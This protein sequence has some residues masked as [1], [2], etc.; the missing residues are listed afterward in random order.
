MILVSIVL[1]V[2]NGEK[3]IEQAIKSVENQTFKDWELIIVDDGSN[4]KTEIIVEKYLNI[5]NRIK[6]YKKINSGLTKSLNFGLKKVKGKYIARLDADDIWMENKLEQ[7]VKVLEQNEEIYIC[8]CAFSEIDE[9]GDFICTQRTIFLKDNSDIQKNLC[10]CNPFFH[11]SVVFRRVILEQIGM[12]NEDFKY[13][14]DYEYWVRILSE[15]KGIN[16]EEILACRRYT[17]DMISEK[18]E[19]EQRRYAIKAKCLAIRQKKLGIS[20]YR[21]IF[22]DLVIVIFPKFII[23]LIRKIKLE[24]KS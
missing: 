2:Y 13:A 14:Q 21:Y 11:S 16:L 17:D 1:S 6:Y 15:Y 24:M 20:S 10:K 19:K 3:Y 12:Y 8:G 4:D 22:N 9:N 18:K 23:K 5:D 7:Q